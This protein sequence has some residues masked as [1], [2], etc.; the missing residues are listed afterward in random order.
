[1]INLISSNKKSF[2]TEGQCQNIIFQSV[3]ILHHHSI[4]YYYLNH[5]YGVK[6][7]V[8]EILKANIYTDA[9]R[10]LICNQMKHYCD[11]QNF[12]NC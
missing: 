9:Q 2:N 1:M 5:P 3:D 12:E 11:Q 4:Y 8:L 7:K 6:R 10:I